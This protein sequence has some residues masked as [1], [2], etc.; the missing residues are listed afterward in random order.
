VVNSDNSLRTGEYE[1]DWEGSH[2]IAYDTEGY[3]R[4]KFR[5]KGCKEDSKSCS[6]VDY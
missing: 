5:I 6:K 4:D 1:V 3:S 2:E